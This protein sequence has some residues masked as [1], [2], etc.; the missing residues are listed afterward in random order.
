MLSNEA[1]GDSS[2]APGQQRLYANC[3]ARHGEITSFFT[4]TLNQI[5]IALVFQTNA[6]CEVDEDDILFQP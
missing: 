6:W 5:P 1:S 3:Y 2:G 4:I